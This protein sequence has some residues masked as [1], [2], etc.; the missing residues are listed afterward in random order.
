MEHSQK[1]AVKEISTEKFMKRYAKLIKMWNDVES[2]LAL[3]MA[4]AP[5]I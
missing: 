5:R 4:L 3:I 2:T 1:K